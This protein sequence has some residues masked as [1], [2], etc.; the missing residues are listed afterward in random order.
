MGLAFSLH[1]RAGHSVQG[2][3]PCTAVFEQGG[4]AQAEPKVLKILRVQH[5]VR[6]EATAQ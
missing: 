3:S 1:W 2:V 5:Q 6:P 4:Q